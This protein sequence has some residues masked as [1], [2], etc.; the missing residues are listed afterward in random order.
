MSGSRNQNSKTEFANSHEDSSKGDGVYIDLYVLN[1]YCCT[2]RFTLDIDV[3][4]GKC[5]LVKNF[6]H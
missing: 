1:R 3:P 2:R 5:G 6:F 4:F